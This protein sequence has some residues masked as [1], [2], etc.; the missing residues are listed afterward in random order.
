MYRDM[1]CEYVEIR[2]NI[3]FFDSVYFCNTCEQNRGNNKV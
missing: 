3:V 2:C 1:G